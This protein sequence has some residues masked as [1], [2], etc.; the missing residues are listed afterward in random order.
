[1]VIISSYVHEKPLLKTKNSAVNLF[2]TLFFVV[3]VFPQTFST[4]TDLNGFPVTSK[5]SPML[6]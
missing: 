6:N 4:G 2:L 1:M 3:V 5:F